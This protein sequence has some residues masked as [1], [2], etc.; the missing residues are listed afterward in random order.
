MKIWILCFILFCGFCACQKE[1]KDT[2]PPV[3]NSLS[4]DAVEVE[5]NDVINVH[6]SLSDNAAL[7]QVRVRIS[8][9]F[10]KS[11]TKWD[12]LSV[13]DISGNSYQGTFSFIVPDS[14]TAGYY[15]ITTQGADVEG[16]GTVD[17][18]LYFTVLQPLSAPQLIGFQTKPPMI[19]NVLYLTSTD[20][21]SFVGQATDDLNL[22][23]VSISLQTATERSIKTVYFNITDTV[24]TWDFATQ[25]DTIFPDYDVYQPSELLI[26][27]LDSD[28]NLTRKTFPIEYTP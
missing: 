5:P 24:T 9:A 12:E 22:S 19:G 20:S 4:V 28:G 2:T 13:R 16:N 27:I 3:I 11:Y 15:Q 8:Q 14:A 17:S 21:L 1:N 18:L 23:K 25:R 6:V 7:N 26:K 10:A